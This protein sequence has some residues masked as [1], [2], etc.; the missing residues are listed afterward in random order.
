MVS[1]LWRLRDQGLL[2]LHSTE[3]LAEMADLFERYLVA[4]EKD[5]TIT[6]HQV[7]DHRHDYPNNREQMKAL[8]RKEEV[9]NGQDQ[10]QP[11]RSLGQDRA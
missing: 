4:Y 8:L 10:S 2:N 3:E 7:R 11:P 6:W 5:K 9:S 1:R